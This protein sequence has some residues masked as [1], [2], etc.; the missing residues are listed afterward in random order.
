M[1]LEDRLRELSRLPAD[2][3]GFEKIT[4]RATRR[5]R[6]RQVAGGALALALVGGGVAVLVSLADDPAPDETVV[7]DVSP[8]P[9]PTPEPDPTPA[10]ASST[11][12]PV[13]T[14]VVAC[15]DEVPQTE[16][17]SL[18][19][20]GDFDGD[21]RPETLAADRP[22]AGPTV[23]RICGSE[24]RV[25]PWD[26]GDGNRPLQVFVVD[27]E[28]DGTD[29][30]IAGGVTGTGPFSGNVVRVVGGRFEG[31]RMGTTVRPGESFGCVDVDGDGLRELVQLEYRLV[32]GETIDTATS[33]EWTRTVLDD[34]GNQMQVDTG[35][36]ALPAQRDAARTVRSGT[37][38]EQIVIPFG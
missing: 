25:E 19:L 36:F 17:A 4:R 18:R 7:T 32:G 23:V 26:A 30:L 38:G 15:P 21:G 10:T 20:A 11:P 3:P 5:R 33:M 37:C 6:T 35:T 1:N 8:A 12:T 31:T 22:D 28:G 24:L 14:G 34:D 2:G 9:S 16:G 27:V 13:A 29:E